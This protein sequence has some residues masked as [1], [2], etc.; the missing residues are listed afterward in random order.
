ME[1]RSFCKLK[2]KK[3]K[4]QLEVGLKVGCIRSRLDKWSRGPRGVMWWVWKRLGGD[5]IRCMGVGL[6]RLLGLGLEWEVVEGGVMR[7]I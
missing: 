6:I 1:K 2:E 4:E 3:S 7:R 5:N